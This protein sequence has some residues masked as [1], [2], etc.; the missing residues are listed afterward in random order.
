MV[1]IGDE[2]AEITLQ[3][4]RE[5][6]TNGSRLATNRNRRESATMGAEMTLQSVAD[7]KDSEASP[8]RRTVKRRRF[9]ED[10]ASWTAKR[11]RFEEDE[12]SWFEEDEASLFEE[13]EASPFEEDEASPVIG[14]AYRPR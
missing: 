5:S 3:N 14:V 12:A 10:E 4:R 2:W 6:A 13:D 11:R 9:E 7:A 8:M 1:R